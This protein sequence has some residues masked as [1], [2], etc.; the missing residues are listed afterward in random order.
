M[1]QLIGALVSV[2]TQA[3]ADPD[4]RPQESMIAELDGLVG[5]A[6]AASRGSLSPTIPIRPEP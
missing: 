3:D 6:L 4:V 2:H 5:E 1:K